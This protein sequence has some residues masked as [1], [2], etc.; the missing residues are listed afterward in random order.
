MS[1]VENL[2]AVLKPKTQTRAKPEEKTV[3]PEGKND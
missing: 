2:R 1:E 3:D